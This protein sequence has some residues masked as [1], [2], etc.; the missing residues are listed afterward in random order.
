[1]GS[2]F[3]WEC[4]CLGESRRWHS[5]VYR[6]VELLCAVGDQRK[7]VVCETCCAK[8]R[9]LPAR[10]IKSGCFPLTMSTVN[11]YWF[12]LCLANLAHPNKSSDRTAHRPRAPPS[13]RKHL[14]RREVGFVD[15][16]DKTE[17]SGQI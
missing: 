13:A 1:M 16:R 4:L 15:G 14:S 17:Q 10:R 8:V 7:N 5:V 9:G 12:S 3:V 2:E 11:N 6:R